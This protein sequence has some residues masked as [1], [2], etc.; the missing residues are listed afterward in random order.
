VNG[1]SSAIA[2]VAVR[3]GIAPTTMPSTVPII[4]KTKTSGWKTCPKP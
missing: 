4:R 3:P 2:I 1:I